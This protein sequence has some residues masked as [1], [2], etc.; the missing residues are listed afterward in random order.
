MAR[1]ELVDRFGSGITS[2]GYSVYTTIDSAMQEAANFAVRDGLLEYDRRHGYR[3]PL[4]Q[5]DLETA[6]DPEIEQALADYPEPGGLRTAL[7][8][9]TDPERNTAR[10]RVAGGAGLTLPWQGMSW[11]ARHIDRDRIGDK[12]ETVDDVLAPGDVI[13]VIDTVSGFPALAQVP[14]AQGALVALDPG[15]GAIAGDSPGRAS[16]RSS[17]PPRSPMASRRPA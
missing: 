9:A 6:G 17:I 12:P 13:Y 11:A 8:V 2:R 16:S 15:D 1:R 4:T 5:L 7:V 3:G 10:L 14:E